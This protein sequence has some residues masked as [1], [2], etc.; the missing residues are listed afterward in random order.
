MAQ[1]SNPIDS[2]AADAKSSV[3]GSLLGAYLQVR[4]Q[5]LQERVVTAQLNQAQR[6]NTAERRSNPGADPT[7]V[8]VSTPAAGVPI[9]V[10]V[11]GAVLL[12]V[13]VIVV[14]KG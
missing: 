6:Q 1:V 2:A 3:L 7:P 9:W 12:A 13:G 10:W 11:G 5:D 14:V 8:K 4:N